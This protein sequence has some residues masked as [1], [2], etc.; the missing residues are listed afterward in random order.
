M[1]ALTIE[2]E[3]V[4]L[5]A[6]A[7]WGQRGSILTGVV[8]QMLPD[9]KPTIGELAHGEVGYPFVSVCTAVP[10]QTSEMESFGDMVR[11][12][13][14]VTCVLVADRDIVQPPSAMWAYKELIEKCYRALNKSR[15]VGNF[16]CDPASNLHYGIVRP[17][18]VVEATGWYK[19][20]KFI[21]AFDVVY[22]T[23]ESPTP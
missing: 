23:E 11:K 13:H 7:I 2:E 6:A 5:T 21:S 15:P 10:P 12:Q 17:R 4:R 20:Q 1:P 18:S 22:K 8:L 19:L 9:Y 14:T 16:E 3:L